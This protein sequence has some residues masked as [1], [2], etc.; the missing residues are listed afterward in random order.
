MLA[1]EQSRRVRVRVIVMRALRCW[2]T[3]EFLVRK[4]ARHNRVR[5]TGVRRYRRTHAPHSPRSAATTPAMSRASAVP[6]CGTWNGREVEGRAVHRSLRARTS[7]LF[8]FPREADTGDVATMCT[9]AARSHD[10]RDAT[11]FPEE[12]KLNRPDA[13]TTAVAVR[14]ARYY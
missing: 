11:L 10:G 2:G 14:A 6:R 7:L 8:C 4:R 13:A 5:A 9:R 12:K 1:A 3:V